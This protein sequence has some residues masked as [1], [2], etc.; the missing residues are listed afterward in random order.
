M[1]FIACLSIIQAHSN[2]SSIA[3]SIKP[4]GGNVFHHKA[5]INV[6]PLE[7]I[8]PFFIFYFFLKAL[9]SLIILGVTY[10]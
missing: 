10:T 5:F 7:I 1:P 3:P 9:E 8:R 6:T 4:L 2:T